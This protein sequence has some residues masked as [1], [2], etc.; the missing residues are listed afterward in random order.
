MSKK[1]KKSQLKVTSLGGEEHK[2]T[3]GKDDVLDLLL[4]IDITGH[5]PDR[6]MEIIQSFADG[7]WIDEEDYW[8]VYWDI[9]SASMN[10]CDNWTFS[11]EGFTAFWDGSEK[12]EIVE[13]IWEGNGGKC[14]VEMT[15]V[16][17]EQSPVRKEIFGE[18]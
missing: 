18:E 13:A 4:T 11:P 5:N 9:S 2:V 14:R 10:F 7:G 12:Q 3:T 8:E 17:L 15:V 6:I 1:K 16:T